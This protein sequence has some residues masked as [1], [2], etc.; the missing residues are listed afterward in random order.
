MTVELAHPS[1]EPLAQRSPIA[2]AHPRWWFV[3]TTPGRILTIGVILASLGILSAFA[4]ATTV[5]NRQT[6]LSTVLNNT[7]PLAFAARGSST[8]RCRW[9]TR[10]RPPRSSPEPSRKRSGSAM[11]KPSPMRRWR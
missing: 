6:Q 10:R 9:P 8:R 5:N 4:I 11:P 1:T 7:E 3:N 2:P